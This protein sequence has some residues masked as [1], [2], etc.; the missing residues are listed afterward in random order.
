MI[1]K[2]NDTGIG[3]RAKLTNTYND[4]N[5]TDAKVV[6]SM[7]KHRITPIVNDKNGDV[8]VVLENIHTSRTGFF[9]CEFTVTFS[10][11][12]IETFPSDSYIKVQVK[13]EV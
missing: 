1:I 9:N 3:L 10:D 6:F 8:T 5:L 12:R 13:A 4:L 7:D 11:G 2:Q